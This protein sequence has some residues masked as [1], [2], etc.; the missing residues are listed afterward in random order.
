MRLFIAINLEK[1]TRDRLVKLQD[2]LRAKSKGGNFTLADNLHITL[3]FLGE[4]TQAQINAAKAVM[5]KIQ[6]EPFDIDVN[7]VGR[8]KREGGD[9][10]WAGVDE[11]PA[12]IKLQNSL[13]TDLIAAGFDLEKRNF[14]PHITLGRRVKTH[15]NPW[16]VTSFGEKAHSIHLMES[17]RVDG[18]LTYTTIYKRGKKLK[19]ITVAAYNPDWPVQFEKIK[20]YLLPHIGHLIIDIHHVGST[21]VPGLSA[22]PIIDFDVE[23]ASM[24]SFPAIKNQ[25]AVLGYRHMGNFGIEGR[26]A[27]KRETPDEFMEYHLYVCPSDSPELVRHIK[28]RDYL[29]ASPVAMAEYGS[30]KMALAKK[31]VT[32]IDGY[33]DGKTAFILKILEL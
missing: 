18:V 13:A 22:K 17:K 32:D 15:A 19:P 24:D 12:L 29:R 10:W 28:L 6:F 23:I 5:D 8:F 4:C 2:Q 1:E 33:I 3:A 9:V 27:F 14:V 7:C 25:L 20:S 31:Y 11:C 26:E 30:L 21:S 16:Q